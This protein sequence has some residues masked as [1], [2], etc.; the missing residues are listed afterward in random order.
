MAS[1]PGFST[2]FLGKSGFIRLGSLMLVTTPA[3]QWIHRGILLNMVAFFVGYDS[4]FLPTKERHLRYFTFLD[5]HFPTISLD[6]STIDSHMRL[7]AVLSIHHLLFN[8][9]RY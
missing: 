5:H 8:E 6:F 4:Y 3:P 7:Q 9:S 2:R 1:L